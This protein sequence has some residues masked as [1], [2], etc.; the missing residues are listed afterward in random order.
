MRIWSDRGTQ[1]KA[2]DKTLRQIIAGFDE[3]A[4]TEFGASKSLYWSFSAPDAPWQNG[5]A[6]SLIKSV[7]KVLTVVIGGQELSF[8]E[9]Q[10]VLFETGDLV[11]ERPIGRHPTSTDDGAYLSPN[12][13]LLGRSTK[14][15]PNVLF[16]NT[17]NLH[18][19]H[20]FT[21]KIVNAFWKKWTQNFFPSLIIQQKWHTASR[22]VKVGDVVIIQDSNQVRGKWKLGRVSCADPSLRDG[23]VRKIEV[24]YKNLDAKTYT[25][26]ERP[27]QRVVVL[28]PVDDEE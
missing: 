7:K 5:C 13:L 3:K 17:S 4:I 11:N 25:T 20:R 23:F 16:S 10:T 18:I 2:A 24:Q 14:E 9:T 12:D 22:N 27:V 28:V 19:R 26:I 15:I 21:Q 6:E 1:L 8:S